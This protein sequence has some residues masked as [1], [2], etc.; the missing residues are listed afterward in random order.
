MAGFIPAFEFSL[1]HD[2]EQI[3]YFCLFSLFLSK[4][5]FIVHLFDS[6]QEAIANLKKAPVTMVPIQGESIRCLEDRMTVIEQ[7]HKCLNKSA[8]VKS[9]VAAESN[10]FDENQRFIQQI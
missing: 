2:Y 7:D 6:A 3:Y 5:Q 9:A 8:E 4:F 10:D 1:I